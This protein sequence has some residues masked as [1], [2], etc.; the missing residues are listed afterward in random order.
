MD[1]IRVIK[2]SMRCLR[3]AFLGLIPVIGPLF[4]V[5]SLVSYR[6]ARR[7][8]GRE[9]NP[10]ARELRWGLAIAILGCV[11]AVPMLALTGLILDKIFSPY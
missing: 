6:R 4:L 7:E 2:Q 9:W 5:R 1:K 3:N 8:A 10:G 11:V